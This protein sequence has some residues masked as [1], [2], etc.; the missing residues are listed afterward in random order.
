MTPETTIEILEDPT[1]AVQKRLLLP[2]GF[3]S[4]KSVLQYLLPVRF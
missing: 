3:G 2:K 4:L 1:E